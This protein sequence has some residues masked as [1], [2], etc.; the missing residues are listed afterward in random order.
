MDDAATTIK[1]MCAVARRLHSCARVMRLRSH[2]G[3]ARHITSTA[4]PLGCR[5]HVGH[6]IEPR[7]TTWSHLGGHQGASEAVLKSYWAI[8]DALTARP[9]VQVPW[10][11]EWEGTPPRKKE[12][13]GRGKRASVS[14]PTRRVLV[15][16]GPQ[17]SR[18]GVETVHSWRRGALAGLPFGSRMSTRSWRRARFAEACNVCAPL[19]MRAFPLERGPRVA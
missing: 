16:L 19:P 9:R 2:A 6:H 1:N 3:L 12:G 13:V 5:R 18:R 17:M 10:G 4:V 14:P 15:G 8:L 11:G 7:S